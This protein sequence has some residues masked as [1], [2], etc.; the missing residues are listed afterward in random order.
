MPS[1]GLSNPTVS[2]MMIVTTAFCTLGTLLP[3]NYLTV[4][5]RLLGNG[6]KFSSVAVVKGKVILALPL[7]LV[8]GSGAKTSDEARIGIGQDRRTG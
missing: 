1:Y 6:R 4:P 3:V 2:Q 7:S 5:Q 8:T